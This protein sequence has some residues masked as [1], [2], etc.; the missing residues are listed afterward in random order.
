MTKPINGVTF[1]LGKAHPIYD[2]LATELNKADRSY[3]WYLRVADCPQFISRIGPVL[4]ERLA[5]SVM[6]A[7]CGGLKLNFYKKQIALWKK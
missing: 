1:G 7:F 4:E 2:A 5:D 6:A 3:A